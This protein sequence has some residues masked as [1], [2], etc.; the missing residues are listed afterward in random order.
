M[1]AIAPEL[2]IHVLKTEKTDKSRWVPAR[3]IQ[4]RVGG[5]TA[6]IQRTATALFAKGKIE[7]MWNATQWEYRI[8]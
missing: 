4:L 7:R 8:K 5:S 3:A 6:S 1:K 2:M